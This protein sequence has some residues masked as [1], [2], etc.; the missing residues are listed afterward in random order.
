MADKADAADE[1]IYADVQRRINQ[2]RLPDH[3][4]SDGECDDCGIDIPEPRREAAPW[5]TTCIDC[6][7]IREMKRS[8]GCV[9]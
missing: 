2:M 8:Q 4:E 5:A 3:I 6:Q 7:G 1:I 9:M